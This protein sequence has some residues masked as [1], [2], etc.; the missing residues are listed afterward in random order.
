[1]AP[2]VLLV[3]EIILMG[4]KITLALIEKTPKEQF[5][6]VWKDQQAF[7]KF[8]ADLRDQILAKFPA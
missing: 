3:L 8:C 2:E 4:E 7:R 1:M 5:E 6:Q